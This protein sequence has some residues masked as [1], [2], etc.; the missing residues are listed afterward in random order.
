MATGDE[1]VLAMN[2]LTE[3]LGF[4]WVPYMS[5]A[6]DID[7]YMLSKYSE[8]MN[9]VTL[10]VRFLRDQEWSLAQILQVLSIMVTAGVAACYSEAY[11]KPA[12]T[13][14]PLQ[15]TDIDYCGAAPRTVPL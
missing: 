3:E 14:L 4:T 6:R 1:R 11:E 8:S 13:F 15:C 10:M 7:Q 2:T 5:L 9:L 12:E